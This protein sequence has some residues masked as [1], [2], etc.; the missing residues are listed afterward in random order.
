MT[1]ASYFLDPLWIGP[2][3]MISTRFLVSGYLRNGKL[4]AM[5]MKITTRPFRLL[6]PVAS[7]AVLEYFLM[8]LGAVNWLEYLPSVTWSDW[9]YTVIPT[10]AGTFISQVLQ[11]AYLI[12]NAA[13]QITYYYCTGVLWTIPVQLQG[14]WQTVLAVIMIREIKTPWKRFSFYAFCIV[15][16]WYALSWGSYYYSGVLLADLD[17]TYKYTKFL[18]ARPLVYYP[19][20]I[21]VILVAQSG[22]T[23]DMI[24]QHTGVNYATYEYGWH[25]D[26]QTGLS[27][28]QAGRSTYPDY[29]IP[30]LNALVS[31]VFMQLIVEITPIVQKFLSL[32]PFQWVFPHIFTIYLIHGFIFWSIGSFVCVNLFAAGLPYWACVLVVF[33]I[34]YATLFGSMPILTPV[35]E[36]M[37]KNVTQSLWEHASQEPAPRRKTLYPFGPD[38]FD[39]S[40]AMGVKGTNT[41]KSEQVTG[42]KNVGKKSNPSVF[43]SALG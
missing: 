18:Y 23:I 10:N 5:A 43:V 42:Q 32:K 27:I 30:R 21:F 20:L 16:H 9:P 29:Y 15:N 2:F 6:I 38:I 31:T 4:D 41:G 13:P 37:G 36:I 33:V 3:L 28:S 19:F 24:V 17:L 34:C 11:L 8:D 26:I 39:E 12:P 25:P 7:I 14:A 1:I 35:I 22:F 40:T